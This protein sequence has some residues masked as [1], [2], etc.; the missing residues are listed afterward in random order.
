MHLCTCLIVHCSRLAK[1]TIT[2]AVLGYSILIFIQTG[3]PDA[4]CTTIKPTRQPQVIES[5]SEP[6]DYN[7]EDSIP[8]LPPPMPS[9]NQLVHTR[10]R[11]RKCLGVLKTDF[12]AEQTSTN[13]YIAKRPRVLKPDSE[14]EQ[15]NDDDFMVPLPSPVLQLAHSGTPSYLEPLATPSISLADDTNEA[16][17]PLEQ[18]Q[19]EFA[20][21]SFEVE[22]GFFPD[23]FPS[24]VE[25]LSPIP[26]DIEPPH[27]Q[28]YKNSSHPHPAEN[29]PQRQQT[30][31]PFY[32]QACLGKSKKNH[33]AQDMMFKRRQ[34]RVKHTANEPIIEIDSDVESYKP[35]SKLAQVWI[36][37]L[38][39]READRE[40]LCNHTS[41]AE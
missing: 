31:K 36:P 17:L 7:T 11:S 39:L 18:F 32:P 19:S 26:K 9:L 25:P 30:E 35:K 34:H 8:P 2:C 16:I 24:T 10:K 27:S 38:G 14:V 15:P 37:E 20:A 13:E 12:E 3:S 29:L 41:M 40:I 23:F 21:S 22:G 5:D 1:Y 28:P 4:S 6:E 33:V